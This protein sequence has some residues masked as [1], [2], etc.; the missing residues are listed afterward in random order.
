MDTWDNIGTV[1]LKHLCRNRCMKQF[2]IFGNFKSH[3]VD[4][5]QTVSK[6]KPWHCP[7]V[8]N[9]NSCLLRENFELFYSWL[10]KQLP[11]C[12]GLG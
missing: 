1:N 10:A 11:V 3:I 6:I 2:V 12:W 8:G 7:T 4:T 5:W 9:V